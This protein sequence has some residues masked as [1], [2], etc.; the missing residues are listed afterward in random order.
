[1]RCSN[2]VPITCCSVLTTLIPVQPMW[3]KYLK[4]DA[5][6]SVAK[7]LPSFQAS[8]PPCSR[9]AGLYCAI[10]CEGTHLCACTYN[11]KEC[12]A[13]AKKFPFL[14]TLPVMVRQ[15]QFPFPSGFCCTIHGHKMQG[16]KSSDMR[17]KTRGRDRRTLVG[18]HPA[19]TTEPQLL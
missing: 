14:P 5:A 17:D 16:R 12:S 1:M 3:R 11:A 10:R 18:E 9:L 8:D 19:T 15:Y 4:G 2:L 6:V 13:E 7:N